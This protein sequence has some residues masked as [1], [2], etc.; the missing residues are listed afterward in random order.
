MV[1]EAVMVREYDEC[2]GPPMGIERRSVLQKVG[3]VEMILANRKWQSTPRCRHDGI[4]NG[5]WR[6]QQAPP[7]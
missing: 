5:H 2:G 6:P 1:F 4:V 3:E 7:E